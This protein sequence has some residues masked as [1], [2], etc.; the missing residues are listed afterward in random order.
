MPDLTVGGT[1]ELHGLSGDD[2]AESPERDKWPDTAEARP[3]NV[4]PW[5]DQRADAMYRFQY[6]SNS[7]R[8][9]AV[10]FPC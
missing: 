4:A 3:A 9:S 8:L 10:Q 7:A 2:R 6:S 1:Y 5:N